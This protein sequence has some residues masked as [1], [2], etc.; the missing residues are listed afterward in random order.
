MY[1]YLY[2]YIYICMCVCVRA[3]VFVCLRIRLP[4][5]FRAGN[6]LE[7]KNPRMDVSIMDSKRM[8]NPKSGMITASPFQ[9]RTCS[10]FPDFAS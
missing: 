9:D 3:C 8:R 7:P 1:R 4:Q 2:L 5:M 6:D 10:L